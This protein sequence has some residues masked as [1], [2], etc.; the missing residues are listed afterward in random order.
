M[1]GLQD[2]LRETFPAHF[3]RVDSR[4]KIDM[5]N[6]EIIKIIED[7]QKECV[8]WYEAMILENPEMKVNSYTE[9]QIKM[10]GKMGIKKEVI[11]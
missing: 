7:I 2:H 6:P 10:A 9:L 5:M 4:Q 11:R 1:K 8:N 3:S